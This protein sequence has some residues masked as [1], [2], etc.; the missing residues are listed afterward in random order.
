MAGDR[1]V[2]FPIA[3]LSVVA[4]FL[5]TTFLG[6]R[7]YDLMRL[8]EGDADKRLQQ[9]Q[10]PVE[11]RL[12]E[13][14]FS[15]LNRYRAKLKELCAGDVGPNGVR[16]TDPR[17]AR[18]ERDTAAFRQDFEPGAE[19]LTVIAAMLP[20]AAFIGVEEAR[21]RVRYA[22]LAGLNAEGYV[23]DDS[24]H[25][26]LLHARRCQRLTGC[27]IELGALLATDNPPPQTWDAALKTLM[28]NRRL[29]SQALA[30]Q[31]G[32]DILYET[33]SAQSEAPG[34]GQPA[35]HGGM[36]RE[37]RRV[38]VL[39]ID[40]TAV[41][42]RWLSAIAILLAEVVPDK[43][44]LRI[45]GPYKSDDLVRALA[46]DLPAVGRAALEIKRASDA[47]AFQKNAQTLARLRLISPFSTAPASQL[48]DATAGLST[49]PECAEGVPGKDCVAEAFEDLLRPIGG[50]AGS[51]P[52]FFRT[53]GTDDGQIRLLVRELCARGLADNTGGRVILLSEWDSIYARTFA[54]A[55]KSELH[56]RKGNRFKLE[57]Y[58]YLRG[59]DG[60][61]VDGAAR[62]VRLVPRGDKPKDDKEPSIEWP[63]SR[64]QRDYVRRLVE[65]IKL[66][67]D[68]GGAKA[69]V[70]AIGVIGTDVND[71]LLLVQALR[72]SFSD[73]VLFT[74]DI[75]AR[76]LHPEAVRYTRNLIVAS[77]L[78]LAL[79]DEILDQ[80]LRARVAP[81]R[82]MYQ[83]AT[84]LGARYASADDKQASLLHPAIEKRL[85]KPILYEIGRD[86]EVE[87][88][89]DKVL[90][91]ERDR[92]L[93]YALLAGGLLL[94]LGGF[95]LGRPAPAMQVALPWNQAAP[96]PFD[97]A[98]A[99][100]AGL[101]VGAW[102]FALGV[103]IEL[104][105]PGHMGPVRVWLLALALMLSFWALVYPG[106]RFPPADRPD[107]YVAPTP[108]WRRQQLALRLLLIV[109]P[110]CLVW[111]WLV[112]EA[113]GMREPFAP[114]SGVSAWP[115]QLL[116]TLAVVLF[117]WFLDYAWGR[118]ATAAHRIGNDYFPA[119]SS[120][121]ADP[122]AMPLSRRMVDAIALLHAWWQD[123][124]RQVRSNW[125]GF[126][127][128]R[129]ERMATGLAEDSIWFWR[130]QV[131][132]DGTV[133]GA[134]VWREYRRLLRNG[135]RLWRLLIWLAVAFIFLSVESYLVGGGQPEIPARGLD[136]RTLF[137]T[138][139]L[140]HVVGTIIL[141]VLVADATVLTWRFI[142]ILKG[143]RTIYPRSTV[144]R[145]AAELGPELQA[146]AAEPIAADVTARTSSG[147][148]PLNSLLDDWIDARLLAQHT[149]AIGPLIVFPF[150]LV[151][152]LVVARS[153]LFDNWAISGPVLAGLVCFV[154]WSIAMAAL[155][156]FGAEIAR[157][158]AVERMEEDLLWL[159]GKG[160]KYKALADRFPT[161]IDKVRKLRQ[162]AFAPFFEQP[163]VQAILVPLGG[164]GGVQLI[165]MFMFARS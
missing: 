17:C 78:P 104:G 93:G 19:N 57:N 164:A 67:A 37:R 24:E 113:G 61:N 84:F 50:T 129:L 2:S 122:L 157:R 119:Q 23:P 25:M 100:V 38:V 133:D 83:T 159:Q 102:G 140:A 46:D 144:E 56:C 89:I 55:L 151:G 150:I 148:A 90:E 63:E 68:G 35:D 76:L 13:D 39:W 30:Q 85:E 143:G 62:Q 73:R 158:R 131:V 163:L 95:M 141:L 112:P 82:D 59:L 127:G 128:E 69:Q 81:F 162:G 111:L 109:L 110:V 51:P 137:W 161:L 154:L 42:P 99:V 152:L 11:A 80:K 28:G 54:Q 86:S 60:A 136:D 126:A 45:I 147:A 75:D 160:D 77:S 58:S 101:E 40:D 118:S 135:P 8:G 149:A 165:E 70:R 124:V 44:R 155:L 9:S 123:R 36:A 92:R 15:A 43:A 153:Q 132:R 91:H 130:P 12:W 52:F 139:I 64:D 18:G 108:A 66:E 4:L 142:G 106:L 16:R 156:N 120:Q 134:L 125:R 115:S 1:G 34:Q 121:P 14:P 47:A 72:A 31:P 88:G 29:L 21:R 138:T 3:A 107:V 7:A 97:L 53:I 87:L 48:R 26:G 27:E 74:T 96:A 94:V 5:S 79:D 22:V 65:Q 41:A 20:G 145:F 49:L 117:A 71:K 32:M 98:T 116:R 6:Q 10:P 33:L 146:V 105:L 103:V 114:T